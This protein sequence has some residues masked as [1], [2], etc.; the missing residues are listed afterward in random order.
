MADWKKWIAVRVQLGWALLFAG[1][2]FGVG[3]VALGWMNS[4]SPYNY[5][6]ITGVGIMLAGVGVGYLLRYRAA[7][8]D[9]HV[10]SRVRAEERDERTVLIRTRAG[11]RAFWVSNA[12]VYVALMWSSFASNGGLPPLD[13]DTLW[14]YLAAGVVIPFGVYVVS[15]LADERT[16]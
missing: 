7:L 15:M 12:F 1:V 9:D 13:G 8:R 14:N 5:R 2:V 11:N 4:G 16:S 3:G 10:A 6:I